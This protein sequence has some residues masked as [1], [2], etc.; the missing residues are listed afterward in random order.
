VEARPVPAGFEADEPAHFG[1]QIGDA[2]RGRG[3]GQT[4]RADDEAEPALLGGEDVLDGDPDSAPGWHLPRACAQASDT[5]RG[6][7]GIEPA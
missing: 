3:T 7:G 2:E 6:V 1:D 4:D 5:G